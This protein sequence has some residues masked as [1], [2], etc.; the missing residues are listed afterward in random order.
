MANWKFKITSMAHIVFLLDSTVTNFYVGKIFL[1]LFILDYLSLTVYL[2]LNKLSMNTFFKVL[3]PVSKLSSELHIYILKRSL[4][5]SPWISQ[6]HLKP[7]SLRLN[8]WSWIQKKFLFHYNL[9]ENYHHLSSYS[10]QGTRSLPRHPPFPHPAYPIHHEV[11]EIES[12][13]YLQ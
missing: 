2:S 10:H 8:S 5:I 1:K 12:K 3:S 13:I 6:R 7:T 9:S 11:W 4:K